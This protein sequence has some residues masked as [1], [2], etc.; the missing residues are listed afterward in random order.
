VKPWIATRSSGTPGLRQEVLRRVQDATRTDPG[1][2]EPVVAALAEVFGG[3]EAHFNVVDCS[4]IAAAAGDPVAPTA[5]LVAS[6]FA[7]GRRTVGDGGMGPAT[8]LACP[9]EQARSVLAVVLVAS[10][11][12]WSAGWAALAEG[13]VTVA[14]GSLLTA[15]SRVLDELLAAQADV[16]DVALADPVH[17]DT[18]QV[19]FAVAARLHGL[20]ENPLLDA[21][22][23]REIAEQKAALEGAARRLAARHSDRSFSPVR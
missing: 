15:R 20:A 11:S 23:R 22:I 3:A 12:G 4:T 7:S 19:L 8:V 5:H 10:P 13:A 1:R 16:A 17:E 6:V 14:T 18:L 21:P 9:V 2:A